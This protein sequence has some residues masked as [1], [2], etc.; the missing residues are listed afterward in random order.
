MAY[1]W[2]ACSFS[3]YMI[4]FKLKYLPGDIFENSLA[5]GLSEFISLTSAGF[6]YTRLGIKMSFVVLFGLAVLGG[7][8][9]LTLG[10]HDLTMMPIFV[11]VAKIGISGGFTLVYVST[12]DVFPTLFCATA[13]GLCNFLARIVTILAPEIAERAPPLPM[14]LFTIVCAGG[15]V[16]IQ[17]IKP[18][19]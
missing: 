16:L 2:G 7:T 18:L 1:M 11:T 5:S 4:V 14:L 3:Y 10:E 6:L 17:F 15:V 8:L 19:N 13:I 9:I 12:V